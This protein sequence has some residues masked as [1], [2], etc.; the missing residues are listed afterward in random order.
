VVTISYAIL[1][2]DEYNEVKKLIELLLKYKKQNDEIVILQDLATE[3]DCFN[4][5]LK[6]NKYLEGLYKSKEILY[7]KHELNNDFA[8]QKNYLNTLCSKDYIFNI[9][10]DEIPDECLVENLH[11]IIGSNENVDLFCLPRINK[12]EGITQEHISKWGWRVDEKNRINWPDWQQRIYKN[13]EI[14]KWERPVHEYLVRFKSYIYFPEKEELAL[15]HYKKIDK[16]ERQNKYY[17]NIIKE[18]IIK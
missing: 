14:I 2:N 4:E 16:Q 5:K 8:Q 7:F 10:A 18:K 6:T 11:E 15:K 1:V 9:D 3:D 12:V 13:N 17:S